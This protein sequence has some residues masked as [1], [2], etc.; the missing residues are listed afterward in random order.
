M[1]RT[2]EEVERRNS[3]PDEQSVA[4]IIGRYL[5]E[6]SENFRK[7]SDLCAEASQITHHFATIH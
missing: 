1:N 6:G 5:S 3:S 2:P 4:T 7:L